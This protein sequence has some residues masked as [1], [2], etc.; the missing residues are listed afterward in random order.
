[1]KH[2]ANITRKMKIEKVLV[3]FLLNLM[4]YEVINTNLIYDYFYIFEK[5]I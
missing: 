1:M 2:Y 4:V 5:V 3:V